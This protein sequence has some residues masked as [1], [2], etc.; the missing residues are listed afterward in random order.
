MHSFL[1]RVLPPSSVVPFSTDFMDLGWISMVSTL[2]SKLTFPY[3][4]LSPLSPLITLIPFIPPYR[5]YPLDSPLLPLSSID[6]GWFFFV[7][8][9]FL[10]WTSASVLCG[11]DAVQIHILISP[12]GVM[13]LGWTLSP[14][15][16]LSFTF[17]FP[18]IP[19]IPPDHP[20]PPS[21]WC[22]FFFVYASFLSWSSASVLRGCDKLL[23]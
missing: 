8:A 23:P 17:L 10:L 5:L 12:F 21:T 7:Y 20:Y 19:L 13:D 22:G 15:S 11:A 16:S 18:L 3:P 6:L 14:L 1:H 4:P 9:S 2:M